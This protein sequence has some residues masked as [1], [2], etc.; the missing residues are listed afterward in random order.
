MATWEA[1]SMGVF[2]LMACFSLGQTVNRESNFL[3]TFSEIFSLL[4]LLLIR[5]YVF[6]T[7]LS[8]CSGELWFISLL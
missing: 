5:L 8:E 3:S 4:N 6:V 1:A 7:M 2:P